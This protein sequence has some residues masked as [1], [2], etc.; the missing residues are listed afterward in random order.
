MQTAS[1]R[2]PKGHHCKMPYL[3]LLHYCFYIQSLNMYEQWKYL[4]RTG[5]RL[6]LT[7]YLKQL[8]G[9]WFPPEV[10]GLR[11]LSSALS[12]GHKCYH[13]THD[14]HLN[15]LLAKATFYH[16]E[17]K[18][19]L[20]P[21]LDVG[22]SRWRSRIPAAC[23]ECGWVEVESC[24]LGLTLHTPPEGWVREKKFCI[25]FDTNFSRYLPRELIIDGSRKCRMGAFCTIAQLQK[26]QVKC[27]KKA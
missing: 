8:S 6:S 3:W 1:V 12:N 26:L 22:E 19:I 13:D 11:L 23:W 27:Q 9:K 25:T 21:L 18:Q 24:I 7:G 2:L 15:I 14:Q 17:T 4:T 5:T 10:D 20:L 16:F